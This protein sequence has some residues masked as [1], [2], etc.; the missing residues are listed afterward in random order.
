MPKLL[1]TED[2]RRADAGTIA[3]MVETGNP[4]RDFTLTSDSGEQISL[5]DLRRKPIGLYF[6]PEDDSRPI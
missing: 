3:A 5:S 2:A 6:Y 1:V 4:A